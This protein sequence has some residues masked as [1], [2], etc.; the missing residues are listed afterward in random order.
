MQSTDRCHLWFG[1]GVFFYLGLAVFGL[2]AMCQKAEAQIF[3]VKSNSTLTPD[4]GERGLNTERL[5]V[6]DSSQGRIGTLDDLG[7]IPEGVTVRA[8]SVSFRT[9][10]ILQSIK[11]GVMTFDF[12]EKTLELEFQYETVSGALKRLVVAKAPRFQ[13]AAI[14]VRGSREEVVV[15]E[16]EFLDGVKIESLPLLEGTRFSKGEEAREADSNGAGVLVSLSIDQLSEHI[17]LARAN[18][19]EREKKTRE[20]HRVLDELLT[21]DLRRLSEAENKRLDRQFP[22]LATVFEVFVNGLREE[23]ENVEGGPTGRSETVGGAGVQL[24]KEQMDPEVIERLRKAYYEFAAVAPV[25]NA[26]DSPRYHS[27]GNIKMEDWVD[28][29]VLSVKGRL[30]D[31]IDLYYLLLSE[32]TKANSSAA[33]LDGSSKAQVAMENAFRVLLEIYV[34]LGKSNDLHLNKGFHIIQSVGFS[35]ASVALGGLATQLAP[36]GMDMPIRIGASVG[37]LLGLADLTGVF[38]SMAKD[39]RIFGRPGGPKPYFWSNPWLK[40]WASR[41]GANS[42]L[43]NFVRNMAAFVSRDGSVLELEDPSFSPR[44]FDMKRSVM[45]GF[46]SHLAEAQQGESG[47]ETSGNQ[48]RVANVMSLCRKVISQGN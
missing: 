37:F 6:L 33:K 3:L 1:M 44:A 14:S 4:G 2:S 22:A 25:Y 12:D 34:T 35:V 5:M 36:E 30:I 8:S 27:E 42:L 45:R 9:E 46:L 16:L 10:G 18:L 11:T 32:A 15:Y 28:A 41:K 29:P 23:I 13:R 21:K 24:R 20:L 38:V 19:E 7:Q 17:A 47:R 26:I 31:L 39:D 40:K 43:E 48:L